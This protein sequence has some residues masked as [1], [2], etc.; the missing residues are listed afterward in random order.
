MFKILE[1]M[2]RKKRK[3]KK[4]NKRNTLVIS[5]NPLWIKVLK[6]SKGENRAILTRF[7]YN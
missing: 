7:I 3:R 1:L 2:R 5:K 4:K 6:N